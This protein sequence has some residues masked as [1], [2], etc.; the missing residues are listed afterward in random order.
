MHA[1]SEHQYSATVMPLT[2]F[3]VL[4][5]VSTLLLLSDDH[6]DIAGIADEEGLRIIGR[7]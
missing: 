7:K 5:T 2:T 3:L 1:R 6:N 4:S